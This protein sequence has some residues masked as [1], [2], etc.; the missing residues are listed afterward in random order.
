MACT[1]T[2]VISHGMSLPAVLEQETVPVLMASPINRVANYD[3][4]DCTASPKFL[5]SET[6]RFWEYRYLQNFLRNGGPI[7]HT[8]I[9]LQKTG[10]SDTSAF[11]NSISDIS[12]PCVLFFLILMS[13]DRLVSERQ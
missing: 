5:A 10:N 4:P 13:D 6:T 2:P 12:M 7:E 3:Q 9:T 8:D 11:I 1:G